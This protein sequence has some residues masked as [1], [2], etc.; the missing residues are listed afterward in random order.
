MVCIMIDIFQ[1]TVFF[2]NSGYAWLF[3]LVIIIT[4]LF[5][6][7]G[8]KTSRA[9]QILAPYNKKLQLLMHFSYK[10]MISKILLLIM[11]TCV[12]YVAL[13]RPQWGVKKEQ[14]KQQGRDLFIALDI[15]R[16]MLAQD[17]NGSRIAFAKKKIKELVNKLGSERVGL[18]LFSGSAFV[19]CPLT[20]DLSAFFL[21]LDSV[22]VETIASG[23]TAMEKAIT[24]VLD[25]YR[26]M[27][28]KKNKLL[29]LFT[30]GEDFSSHLAE[31]QKQAHEE[32]LSIFAC[33]I[34]TLQGAP[35]PLFNEQGIL[36]GHQKDKQGN[37]VVSKM[38]EAE[39]K[40]LVQVVGGK[41][42]R[43]TYDDEDINSIV[44][45]LYSFEKEQFDHMD[46]DRHIDRYGIFIAFAFCL[47]LLEWA[48]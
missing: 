34:G 6:Y 32:G 11:A 42:I 40:K 46:Q 5:W 25:V 47:F 28:T 14:I 10:K 21:F 31:V 30:D 33:G 12:L 43:M 27:P 22:D 15:S 45:N 9:V 8:I 3:I 7:K 41:Y 20:T 35:I 44:Q 23:A 24:V 1:K 36:V 26:T 39:L 38:Q 16:S 19:Q 4:A 17:C 48:L 18:V 13:L 29:V 2:A 37:I